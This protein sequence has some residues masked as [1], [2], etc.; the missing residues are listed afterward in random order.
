MEPMKVNLEEI[1]SLSTQWT[2][3]PNDAGVKA[4]RA[5]LGPGDCVRALLGPSV[6]KMGIPRDGHSL[7]EPPA[8]DGTAVNRL[9]K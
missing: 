6:P 4:I 1:E 9:A 7:F 3:N 8:A 2:A 5:L